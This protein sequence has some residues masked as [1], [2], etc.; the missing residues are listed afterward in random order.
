MVA[1][2]TRRLSAPCLQIPAC[3]HV[4]GPKPS[5]YTCSI[6]A[7]SIL[8]TQIRRGCARWQAGCSR[9]APNGAEAK[10][11]CVTD[12]RCRWISQFPCEEL[13]L[14]YSLTAACLLVAGQVQPSWSLWVQEG[15]RTYDGFFDLGCNVWQCE[16]QRH[17]VSTMKGIC[18][19]YSE[20][21]G[22]TARPCSWRR[23]WDTWS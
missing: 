3:M 11:C 1:L 10:M 6:G 2:L 13:T 4:G 15:E 23:P 17:F 8:R 12:C 20:Y 16:R 5:L 7:P 21:V 22:C 19:E 9:L 18:S 14:F